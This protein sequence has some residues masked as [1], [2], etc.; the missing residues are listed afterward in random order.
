MLRDVHFPDKGSTHVCNTNA[1]FV[2]KAQQTRNRRELP[3]LHRTHIPDLQHYKAFCFTETPV[4]GPPRSE[5]R[6][7]CRPSLLVFT[8]DTPGG[9]AAG[10]AGGR[11]EPSSDLRLSVL[12][13]AEGAGRQT[14][15][16]L[17]DRGPAVNATQALGPREAR[18]LPS[19]PQP[20]TPPCLG[21][22]NSRA[23][24]QAGRCPA[25]SFLPTASPLSC[26]PGDGRG[27]GKILGRCL[28][29]TSAPSAYLRPC[30][31]ATANC[32]LINE[33]I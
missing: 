33:A 9:Q 28:A 17:S 31:L 22:G 10:S 16:C 3:Y 12:P 15:R 30:H 25:L 6:Q 29:S 8:G 18:V 14:G 21:R 1:S 32:L 2:I 11:A 5:T 20:K 26:C 7:G 19:L 24:G 27:E 13:S 4:M 23:S